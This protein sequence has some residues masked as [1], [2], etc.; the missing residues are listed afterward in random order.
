MVLSKDQ[1]AG[2]TPAL[3]QFSSVFSQILKFFPRAEFGEF[4]NKHGGDRHAKGFTCWT[5]FRLD[6]LL[7][8]RTCP[9]ATRDHGWPAIVRRK[10]ATFGHRRP[11]AIDPGLRE[12]AQTV[13][14][15]S[16]RIRGPCLIV[17]E[18][19]SPVFGS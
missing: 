16:R 1:E 11:C 13:G 5:Q 9:V 19:C 4:V 10:A 18:G 17:A 2:G 12:R 15:L 6:D 8:A 14:D 7:P 3:S